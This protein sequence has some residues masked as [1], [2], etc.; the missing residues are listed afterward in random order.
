MKRGEKFKEHG[1]NP[2]KPKIFDLGVLPWGSANL[3]P[4]AIAV[5]G[6]RGC[7]FPIGDVRT[8]QFHFCNAKREPGKAYCPAHEAACHQCKMKRTTS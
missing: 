3:T 4:T 2:S 5:I 8:D 6:V 7:R 1:P